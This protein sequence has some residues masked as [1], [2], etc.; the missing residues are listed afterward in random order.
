MCRS[1]GWIVSPD[2]SDGSVRHLSEALKPEEMDHLG[3]QSVFRGLG[4][5]AKLVV[6]KTYILLRPLFKVRSRKK[7]RTLTLREKWHFLPHLKN[8]CSFYIVHTH[9]LDYHLPMKLVKD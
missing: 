1:W 5:G 8:L 4:S 6:G 9:I 7:L 2:G 3:L